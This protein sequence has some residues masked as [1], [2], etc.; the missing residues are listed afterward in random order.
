MKTFYEVL[1][2][3]NT[4]SEAEIKEQYRLLIQAWHPDKFSN[5]TQKD[6]ALEKAKE[7]NQAYDVLGR[8]EKRRQY[9]R[10]LSAAQP[11]PPAPSRPP[12]PPPVH[13]DYEPPRASRSEPPPGA[14]VGVS[15]LADLRWL[16]LFGDEYSYRLDE[17][18]ERALTGGDFHYRLADWPTGDRSGART[19]WQNESY[20]VEVLK[21]PYQLIAGETSRCYTGQASLTSVTIGLDRDTSPEASFGI[22]LNLAYLGDDPQEARRFPDMLGKAIPSAYFAFCMTKAGEWSLRSFRGWQDQH[23]TV[24]EQGFSADI[25]RSVERGRPLEISGV[26]RDCLPPG[27]EQVRLRLGVNSTLICDTF[28]S[29]R[30]WRRGGVVVDAPA[31]RPGVIQGMRFSDFQSLFLSQY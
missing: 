18:E 14:R 21:S 28:A 27:R 7:I 31:S 12:S 23:G 15:P 13:E 2:V 19:Y 22:L 20:R 30:A 9:D 29:G 26:V 24:V 8:P 10:E 25:R 3:A 17:R 5:P 16:L 6:R 4:A 1:D 11:A